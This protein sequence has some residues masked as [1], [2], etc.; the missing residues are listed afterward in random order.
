MRRG[1]TNSGTGD[2]ESAHHLA[3][4]RH[5]LSTLRSLSQ[6]RNPLGMNFNL[7]VY[8]I[9]VVPHGLEEDGLLHTTCGSP[10]YVVPEII[11][12]RGYDGATSDTWSCGVILYVILTGYLPF[13][14]R[15]MA[16]LYQKITAIQSNGIA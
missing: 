14:D 8:S 11:S 6:K 15:N 3:H 12:N 13:D 9:D 16:V 4:A 7:T 10:N 2:S 1:D 5:T